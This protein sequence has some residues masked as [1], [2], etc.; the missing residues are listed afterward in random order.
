MTKPKFTPGSTG[1]SSIELS[2]VVFEVLSCHHTPIRGLGVE[3]VMFTFCVTV[4]VQSVVLV[5]L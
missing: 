1:R 2:V 3:H 5:V 4:L